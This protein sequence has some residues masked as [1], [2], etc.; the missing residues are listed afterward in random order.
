MVRERLPHDSYPAASVDL[1]ESLACRPETDAAG[2]GV[3]NVKARL[4]VCPVENGAGRVGGRL[5]ALANDREQRVAVKALTAR[6][7]AL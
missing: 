3:A 4:A 5:A 6:A 1:E 2:W 7:G